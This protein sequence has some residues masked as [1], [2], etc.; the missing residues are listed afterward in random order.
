MRATR[1]APRL[2]AALLL[3]APAAVTAQ[4]LSPERPIDQARDL[5][6]A[7][8]EAAAAVGPAVVSI[9]STRVQRPGQGMEGGDPHE[10]F[11]RFFGGRG[12]PPREGYKQTGLG[13]G[14][15]VRADGHILTNN[16]V[17]EDADEVT[18]RFA[19]GKEK[20]A[21]V[22]GT[23]PKTDL[24]VIQVEGSGYRTAEL[25]DSDR[26]EVGEW[27]LAVGN[28]FGLNS[29]LTAG[30]VSAKGRANMGIVD[31]EDFI[32]TDAAINPG[33]SG[34]PLVNL[35][36]KVVGINTAIFSRSGGYMGIGF[37]IPANM[38]R[39]VME[40]ILT[41][42]KV[43][44]GWLGVQIQDLNPGL[45]RSF[46]YEGEK[47]VLIG[48]VLDGGPAARAG[49][50]EGDIIVAV[51]QGPVRDVNDVRNKVAA[52]KPGSKIEV[53]VVRGGAHRRLPVEVGE[54]EPEEREEA[55][56]A[57][58]GE[59]SMALGLTVRTLSPDIT[60]QLDLE[61]G[62]RGVVVTAV[63]PG[64]RADDAGIQTRDV[65]TSVQG[66]AVADIAAFRREVGKHPDGV[67]LRI[68]R[69][70]GSLY[71]FVPASE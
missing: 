36:G 48:Q 17:V 38:A 68:Q 40:S 47:G 55:R 26:L 39:G 53:E 52:V 6:R 43:V 2:L 50:L 67:R 19:D 1:F 31:Y 57:G 70:G 35:E 66:V 46:G 20:K 61:D 18:V 5:S 21:K 37:S 62:V 27:V 14:I 8:K 3:L 12:M 15:V 13:S 54:Q 23:D 49:L 58:R 28:A 30:I 51:G 64:G 41:Q 44:R 71:V 16:H 11:E 33:N 45:A 7:F 29:T 32:Q 9:Q 25:G 10:F 56:I 65:I 22:I 60:R 69:R 42:G 63:E 34:G 24:A 4:A 59:D